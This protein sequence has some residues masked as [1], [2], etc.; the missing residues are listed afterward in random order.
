MRALICREFGPVESLEL[1]DIPAPVPG[2]DQMLLDIAATSVNFA[3]S[4]MVDGRYQTKP[5]FP[6]SPGL[7]GAGVV[8]AVGANVKTFKPGDKVV[9]T[10]WRVGEAHWGGYA[11]KARVKAD[12]LVPLPAGL[13]TRAAMAVGTAGFTAMLAVIVK[14][15]VV[16]RCLVFIGSVLSG[17]GGCPS[18]PTDDKSLRNTA[19]TAPWTTG[20]RTGR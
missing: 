3:D 7:E 6:F 9:L 19:G 14:T 17:H 18:Q 10:G 5:A 4:I 2:P 15:A 13:D 1:A 12:W 8:A 16:N 20:L 11:Q